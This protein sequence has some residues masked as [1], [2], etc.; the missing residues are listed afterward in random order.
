MLFRSGGTF[1]A[2]VRIR[3][4][5]ERPGT[6][7]VQL[8]ARDVHASITRPVAQLLGYHRVTLEP[9]E[10][11]VVRFEV[12]TARLAFT[13]LRHERIVEPGQV[14]LWVGGS[15]ADK[16]TV[17][18]ITIT[19]AVHRVTVAD[20]RLVQSQVERVLEASRGTAAVPV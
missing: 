14:D 19:G 9:G 17:A 6:D 10:E 1:S 7:L 5:G 20:G 16:Q 18:E 13:G 2:S 11:A 15:C 4:T 12:P 3:N 8:Y